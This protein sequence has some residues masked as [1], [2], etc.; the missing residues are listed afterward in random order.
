[1]EDVEGDMVFISDKN[2]NL[3]SQFFQKNG[4]FAAENPNFKNLGKVLSKAG[5]ED[6]NNLIFLL[7]NTGDNRFNSETGG[8]ERYLA[9]QI[10][11]F[12]FDD[13]VIS[14]SLKEQGS[15]V[16][17]IHVFNLGNVYVP[18]STFLKATGEALNNINDDYMNFVKVKVTPGAAVFNN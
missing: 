15:K 17:R 16:N 5:I 13:V 9:M 2:Y 8:I 1:L 11:N 14:E 4:G 10:A 7:A 12:L 3:Q 18:L 6:I